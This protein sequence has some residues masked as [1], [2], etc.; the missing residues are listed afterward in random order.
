MGE[1]QVI[2]INIAMKSMVINWEEYAKKK[3]R[4]YKSGFSSF[5][6]YLFLAL[7]VFG[8]GSTLIITYFYPSLFNFVVLGIYIILFIY[9]TF[10]KKKKHG[11]IETNAGNPVPFAVVSLHDE[12][13]NEKKRFAVTDAVGRYYLLA[14]NGHYKMKAKGQPVSGNAFEKQGNV[15]VDDGIV[16]K[17]IIV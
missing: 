16:R 9:Q 11:S 17:D 1:D 12:G 2:L 5:K 4:Q 15:K 10:F 13:T 7:Y 14:D 6:K 3:V 8:F